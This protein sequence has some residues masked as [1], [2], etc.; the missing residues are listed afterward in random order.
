MPQASARSAS[1]KTSRNAE[2]WVASWRFS[3]TNIPKC[4]SL[5]PRWPRP[6]PRRA[7]TSPW[8]ED[9]RPREGT[10]EPKCHAVRVDTDPRGGCRQEA[11][12]ALTPGRLRRGR[13]PFVPCGPLH[14]HACRYLLRP[15]LAPERLTESS[16]GQLL[17]ERPHP[18]RD[19]SSHLLLDPLELIEKLSVLIPPPRFHLLRIHGVLAPRAQLRSDVVPR[20]SRDAELGGGQAPSPSPPEPR[21]GPSS[22]AGRLGRPS[23]RP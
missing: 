3:S 2:A 19:G 12:E 6:T 15:P 1:S 16:G 7:A 4:T 5:A 13:R 8:P 14:Y 17:Y 11:A 9:A 10:V 22:G 18:R 23:G 21:S 20:S